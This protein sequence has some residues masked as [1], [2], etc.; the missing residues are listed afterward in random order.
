MDLWPI[1]LALTGAILLVL[2]I[3]APLFPPAFPY[4]LGEPMA[5]RSQGF[6]DFLST[7][8]TARVHGGNTIEIL[9]DGERFY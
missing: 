9:P 7:S 3:L 4:R 8:T 6:L 2:F 5:V 1:V